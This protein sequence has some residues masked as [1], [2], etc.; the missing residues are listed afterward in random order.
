MIAIANQKGGV[1][2]TT[3]AV[4]LG[5]ALGHM[6]KR[7]LLIDADPQ[8]SLTRSCNISKPDD[9]DVTLSELLAYQ[10]SGDSKDMIYDDP[11]RHFENID[12]IPSNISLSGTETALFNCMSRESV[13]KR[14]IRPLRDMYDTILIDCMPSLGMMT[15]NSLVAA[16]SVIIPCEPSYLSV[17]GLD[18]L[19]HS[20]SRIKRQINPE[21][22][23][24]GVLMTMVDSRTNNARD[25]T[26]ALRDAMGININVFNIE[27]IDINHNLVY[28]YHGDE[29]GYHYSISTPKTKNGIRKVIMTQAV[30]DA[31]HMERKFQE[32]L[33]LKSIDVIDGYKNFVFI[34]KNNH[35]QTYNKLNKIIENIITDYN[36]WIRSIGITDQNELLPHFSCHI[37]RHTYATRLLESGAAIKF[38]SAQM[39]HSDIQ[40]TYDN[41]IDVTDEFKRVQIRP[42]EKYM[43]SVLGE[44]SSE[45]TDL[46]DYIS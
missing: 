23:I 24:E 9:L 25:I 34:G 13:L 39:G 29:S 2:K 44:T 38:I 36:K 17:K 20:I 28:Y 26:R 33:G 35:V 5:V 27:I 14:T 3:T 31:F 18:L 12:L 7:V 42:F 32:F 8:G 37:L 30:I 1:G 4:N 15:I 45:I 10:M 41:Y 43:D 40:I 16:D 19:L 46:S 21:L 6:G 11:I 22:K